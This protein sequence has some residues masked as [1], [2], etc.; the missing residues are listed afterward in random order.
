MDD[1]RWYVELDDGVG[2]DKSARDD[3]PLEVGDNFVCSDGTPW[4]IVEADPARRFARAV[5]DS[6]RI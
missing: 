3:G 4:R 1:E 6:E 2:A 5:P